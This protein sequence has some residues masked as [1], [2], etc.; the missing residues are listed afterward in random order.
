MILTMAALV[1]LILVAI[2][3]YYYW[4]NRHR[5]CTDVEKYYGRFCKVL[6]KLGMA[7]S[8]S[9]GPVEYSKRVCATRQD[10]STEINAITS[11]YVELRYANVSARR[12]KLKTFKA[13]VKHFK[14]GL[15]SAA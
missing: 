9:E 8:P 10:L 13:Y 1:S 2:A 7:R 6:R 15:R 3:A 12:E 14:P 5:R 11:L 4:K